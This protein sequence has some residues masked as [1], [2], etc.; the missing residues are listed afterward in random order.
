MVAADLRFHVNVGG[1]TQR[2]MGEMDIHFVLVSS[3]GNPFA[4]GT[5]PTSQVYLINLFK[6]P[7][8]PVPGLAT[9]FPA[10]GIRHDPRGCAPGVC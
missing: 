2:I 7:A 5:T 3:T 6:R 4:G 9:W 1:V 10:R 8:Q